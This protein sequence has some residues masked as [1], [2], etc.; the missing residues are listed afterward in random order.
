MKHTV[1]LI[2]DD[3]EL[4]ELMRDALELNGYSVVAAI[5]GQD[6]LERLSSVDDV[7]LVLLD[8]LMPRMNGWEFYAATRQRD[9]LVDVPV[10]VHSS[11]ARDAPEGVTRVLEKPLQLELLLS[12]VREFCAFTRA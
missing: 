8:L 1:L 10:I 2:E 9:E 6:A 4:R 3:E 5:D 11:V 12:T 7:C